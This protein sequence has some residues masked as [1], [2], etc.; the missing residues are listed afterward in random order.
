MNNTVIKEAIVVGIATIIIGQMVGFTMGKYI[1]K[2]PNI[3]REC[4]EWNKNH[5]MEW[6]LFVTGFLI[7]I[8]CEYFGINKWY[9]KNG[10]ACKN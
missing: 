10:S 3:K 9:C 7:H 4:K 1:F 5:V 6:S 8:L 2:Q